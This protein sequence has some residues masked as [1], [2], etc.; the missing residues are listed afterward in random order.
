[1]WFAILAPVQAV[2]NLGCL[3]RLTGLQRMNYER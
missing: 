1:M 3:K 2:E